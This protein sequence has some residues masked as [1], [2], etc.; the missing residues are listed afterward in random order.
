MFR[1][2]NLIVAIVAVSG[3]QAAA[4]M[5]SE[6]DH[7]N[8]LIPALAALVIQALGIAFLYGTLWQRVRNHDRT[9]EE[10]KAHALQQDAS[11]SAVIV[12]AATAA[13]TAVAAAHGAYRRKT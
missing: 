3:G 1:T 12:A 10:I 9:M 8:G 11:I 4:F 6:G 2:L 5:L 13:A 7:M